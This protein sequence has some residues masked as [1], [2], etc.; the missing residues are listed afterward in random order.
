MVFADEHAALELVSQ[1]SMQSAAR[2]V[3]HSKQVPLLDAE[4]RRSYSR[5]STPTAKD[6]QTGA[7]SLDFQIMYANSTVN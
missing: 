1:G 6:M 4:R 3:S 2:R 7:P 5:A